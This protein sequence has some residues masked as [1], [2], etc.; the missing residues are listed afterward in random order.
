MAFT[1]A[2]S[3]APVAALAGPCGDAVTQFEQK[4]RVESKK[5]SAVECIDRSIGTNNRWHIGL[6]DAEAETQC[7]GH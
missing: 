4:V 1:L 5:P 2:V 7:L 6:K 3:F